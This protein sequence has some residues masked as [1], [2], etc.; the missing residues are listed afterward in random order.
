MLQTTSKLFT[1]K[2]KVLITS[3]WLI[4]SQQAITAF[5]CCQSSSNNSCGWV[6]YIRARRNNGM[7]PGS[8]TPC[9]HLESMLASAWPSIRATFFCEYPLQH[10]NNFNLLGNRP[11]F[12]SMHKVYARSENEIR[13]G[14]LLIMQILWITLFLRIIA[15]QFFML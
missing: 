9:S 2:E 3:K 5:I 11:L 6:P 14:N 8:A 7:M 4:K 15:L 12:S 13:E 10:L 1:H